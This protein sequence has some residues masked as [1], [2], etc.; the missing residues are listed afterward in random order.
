MSSIAANV[1]AG[2]PHQLL[3]D[4]PRRLQ[5]RP[6]DR[7]R[8]F[9]DGRLVRCIIG[10]RI[11]IF[12]CTD[13]RRLQHQKH[14]RMLSL[15]PLVLARAQFGLNI[16]FHILFPTISMSLAWFLVFF[17]WRHLRTGEPAW[18]DAYRQWVKI[19]ALTFAMGMVSGI[20]MSF[21]FGTTQE[22]RR[23]RP[24]TPIA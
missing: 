3:Q 20:V 19:F 21:Q 24:R 23:R 10:R 7:R 2:A 22:S 16:A 14:Y 9:E 17:R 1:A 8:R 4:F 13:S 6:P 15:D 5:S 18:L 12:G 11:V